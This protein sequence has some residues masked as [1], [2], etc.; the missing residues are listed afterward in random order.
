MKNAFPPLN[1]LV[2]NK[3]SDDVVEVL[4]NATKKVVESQEWKTFIAENAL[5]ELYVQYPTVA[6]AEAFYKSW[7]SMVSWMLY[8]AGVTKFSPSDFGIEK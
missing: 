5:E 6:D 2:S 4:R 3:I 1:F 7:E 8:D